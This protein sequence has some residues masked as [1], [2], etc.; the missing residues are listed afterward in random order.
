MT[1]ENDGTGATPEGD[2]PFAYLYRQE[3]GEGAPAPQGG[4]RRSYNQVRAVGERQYGG[5]SSQYGPGTQQTAAFG[6]QPNAHYAAPE[7]MPGGRAAAPQHHG[8]NGG[9]HGHGPGHGG[10]GGGRSRNGLLVGALAVVA[11]VVIGI[12]AAIYFNSSGQSQA[13]NSGAAS[14]GAGDGGKQKP[15]GEKLRKGKPIGK[16]QDAATFQLAGGAAAASD[17]PGSAS[18]GGSYVGSMNTTGAS[19][20]WTADNVPKAGLYTLYVRYGVP[21]KDANSTL[22]VNGK[23]R[24]Q[25]LNMSNFGG[26]EEGDWEKGWTRTYAYVDLKQ[27]SNTFKISCEDGNNC[28]FNLDQVWLKAG[29]LR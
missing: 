7:T 17:V 20:T 3:G 18:S 25:P 14:A 19:A 15:G 23:P 27:G 4:P 11:A 6:Q 24:S 21:G 5:Y 8:G 26:A 10:S 22:S 13:D 9:G 12:G 28:E 29:K 16:K 1:A 2:D